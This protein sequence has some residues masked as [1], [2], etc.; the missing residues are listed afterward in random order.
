MNDWKYDPNHSQLLEDLLDCQTTLCSILQDFSKWALNQ[1]QDIR[2]RFLQFQKKYLSKT[3][4]RSISMFFS[5]DFAMEAFSKYLA[6]HYDTSFSLS[7]FQSS[8]MNVWK[9]N[10]L[11][12]L[13]NAELLKYLF[14][15]LL[16][17]GAFS[18]K[19]PE[20]RQLCKNYCNGVCSKD[21]I[22]RCNGITE[23]CDP[24]SVLL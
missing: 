16:E 2:S 11:R 1:N 17:E 12:N 5:F 24:D 19:I 10:R 20:T 13:N 14:D 22:C 8:Y 21:C 9:K 18:C 7:T 6:E 23:Y 4:D 15:K 3:D